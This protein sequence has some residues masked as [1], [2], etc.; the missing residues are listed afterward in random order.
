MLGLVAIYYISD[1]IAALL[2]AVIIASALEPAILWLKTR[3]IPRILSVITL[4]VISGSLI[5]FFIYLIVPLISE[6]LASA[7]SA[8]PGF[9]QEI[10]REIRRFG[11]LPITPFFSEGTEAFLRAPSEYLTRLSRTSFDL[12]SGFFGGV[13][14]LIL[15][16]VFSFYLA[17]QERGIE[18]FLKLITP[19]KHEEYVLDLWA[20]S[21][22]KL[23]YWV[24]AQVLLG[25]IVGVLIFLG[26]T[27]LGLRYAL[28]FAIIAA[29]L[30]VIPVA[31]PILAAVPAVATAFFVSPLLALTVTLLYFAVQQVESHV[32]VPVVMRR[33]VGLSPLIVVLALVIGAKLAGIVGILLAVP[34]TAIG[35]EFLDDWDKKKRSIMPG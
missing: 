8:Y 30:E 5:G 13:F 24:R 32:I 21:Q 6:E 22:R 27:F 16:L 2:F 33:A 23:G 25:A 19:L 29:M 14:S 17:I 31:G 26:L 15:I 4:Y 3:R 12:V 18:S 11:V 9:Q 28:I 1:V 7:S 10:V 34:L 20:R 35:A